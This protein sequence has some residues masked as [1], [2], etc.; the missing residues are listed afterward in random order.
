MRNC[1]AGF[2]YVPK[3][4]PKNCFIIERVTLLLGKFI[5]KPLRDYMGIRKEER[6]IRPRAERVPMSQRVD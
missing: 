3:G 6:V 2:W 5:S 4:P 1:T